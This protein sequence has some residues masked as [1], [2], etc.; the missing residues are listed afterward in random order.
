MI[1]HF[2]NLLLLR[3]PPTRL[4]IIRRALLRLAGIDIAHGAKMC[5]GGW[6]YGNGRVFIGANSWFSPECTIYSHLDAAIEIGANCDIGPQVVFVT[7]SHEFGPAERRAGPGI[8]EPIRVGNG[9]WIGARS[10]IL[11]GV[12]IGHGCI[13][14]AGAVVV[15]S[16]PPNSFAAGVPATVKRHL[17]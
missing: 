8:A 9:C 4:F 15:T 11:G 5:G 13:I 10:T 17:D 16:L 1:R 3:L 12:E 7:G 2:V 6:I 14:G